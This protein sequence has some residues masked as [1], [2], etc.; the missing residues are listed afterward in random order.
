MGGGVGLR[1]RV[2]PGSYKMG[3]GVGLQNRVRVVI[4]WGVGLV[5]G[6]GSE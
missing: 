1:N 5:Y 6:I 2:R 4:K 3:G